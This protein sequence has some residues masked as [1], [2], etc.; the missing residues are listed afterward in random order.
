ML[1]ALMT[2]VTIGAFILGITVSWLAKG[3][4]EDFIENAAYAKSVTHPEMLDE[5]GNILQ[6]ELIYIRPNFDVWDEI[7]QEDDD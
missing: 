2:L 7:E 3:Y 4:V 6:D 5:N 1:I